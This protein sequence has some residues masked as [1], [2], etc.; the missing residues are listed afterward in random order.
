VEVDFK[1]LGHIQGQSI[2]HLWQ[3]WRV[4]ELRS[5]Q[6]NCVHTN[7][8]TVILNKLK[9]PLEPSLLVCIGFRNYSSSA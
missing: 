3:L 1:H 2:Q 6:Q 7:I 9:M 4:C 5:G 8:E